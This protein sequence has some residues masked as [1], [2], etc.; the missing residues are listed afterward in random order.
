[1]GLYIYITEE[2]T[3]RLKTVS[4]PELNELFQEALQADESLLIEEDYRRIKKKGYKGWL[5]GEKEKTFDY[6]VYHESRAHDGSAYQAQQVYG[7]SSTKLSAMTYLFGIINGAF[8]NEK[9]HIASRDQ[10]KKTSN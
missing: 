3:K 9:K 2:E 6:T 1:M 7:I 5:M 8:A 10:H 4:D